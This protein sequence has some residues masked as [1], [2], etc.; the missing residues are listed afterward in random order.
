MAQICYSPS[1]RTR[2]VAAVFWFVVANMFWSPFSSSV[3]TA[4]DGFKG[5]VQPF[6]ETKPPAPAPNTPFFDAEGKPHL[7]SEYK[8]R[9]V[10][11]NFWATWCAACMLEMPALNE[12]QAAMEG[13]GLTVLTVNQDMDDTISVSRELESRRLTRL[14]AHTDLNRILGV[15]LEQTM[16]PTTILIDP[17]GRIVGQLVGPA[18]W[19][20]PEAMEL[21]RRYLP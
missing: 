2:L 9:V 21:I 13:E 10:L 8:G 1:I 3:A 19:D 6:V 15:A 12:L 16:L 17:K 5:Y 14:T 20:S 4:A 7:L 18:E 11:L